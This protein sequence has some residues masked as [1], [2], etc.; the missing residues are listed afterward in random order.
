MHH[1]T[2]RKLVA[3]ALRSGEF[4]QTKHCLS[5]GESFCCLG[6][7]CEVFMRNGGTLTKVH[8]GNLIRYVEEDGERHLTTLPHV[9]QEW[10][11]MDA[12][13]QFT[14]GEYKSYLIFENDT[15]H[16]TFPEIATLFETANFHV[17][18]KS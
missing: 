15:Y 6:V 13:G 17:A 10:L 5:D 2:N 16:K 9:V 4:K 18:A 7:A 1:L 3:D 11:G 8:D 12:G 14:L